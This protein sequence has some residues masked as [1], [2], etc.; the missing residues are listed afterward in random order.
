MFKKFFSETLIICI[1]ILVTLSFATWLNFS[2]NNLDYLQWKS[3]D[4]YAFHGVLLKLH[5]SILNLDVRSFFAFSFYSY[6]LIF[7]FIN[8]LSI[9]PFISDPT[10]ELI[11]FMPK[12]VSTAFFILCL[13]FLNFLMKELKIDKSLRFGGFIFI[14]LMPGMWF[15][16]NWF[17][18]DLMMTSFLLISIYFLSKNSF[19]LKN[20][21]DF[22]LI[23]W[24]IAIAIK[25]QAITYAP[26]FFWVLCK[27]ALSK[28]SYLNEFK[29]T[30]KIFLFIILIYVLLNP[31]LFHLDGINAWIENI[32]SEFFNASSSEGNPKVPL[33][34]KLSYGVF[35]YYLAP[36]LFAMIL[37]CS[38]YKI[39]ED[40]YKKNFSLMGA[41][42]LTFFINIL[43]L[44]FFI[45]KG[46]NSYYLPTIFL[47]AI[48]IFYFLDKVKIK[49]NKFLILIALISVHGH[50]F[51]SDFEKIISYRFQDKI[52]S[53]DSVYNYQPKVYSLEQLKQKEQSLINLFEK[54]IDKKSLILSSAYIGLPLKKLNLSYEQVKIIYGDISK[55]DVMWFV[56]AE[57]PNNYLLIKKINSQNLIND[58]S[59]MIL[60][61][62][63]KI[64][65]TDEIYCCF[66]IKTETI[67]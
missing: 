15:N 44:I 24:G 17:H 19:T 1:S 42:S 25:I 18:P 10:S 27:R 31:Y 7:F 36:F 32:K 67:N 3:L 52:V 53:R 29:L 57:G 5:Y 56:S 60:P 61:L 35:D 9:L 45:N 6:G 63:Q 48:I 49:L 65:I 47:S 11:I 59:R 38:L 26:I 37:V 22:S 23:F 40:L 51:F 33:S 28:K 54:K 20:Y 64:K 43:F 50:Y 13:I 34:T 58:F 21:D 66:L 30:L 14:I 62:G 2:W 8:Y 55:S 39:V 46:W 12:M 4:E 16:V 41:I